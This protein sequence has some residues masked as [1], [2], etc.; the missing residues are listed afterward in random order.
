M[1]E[2][3]KS[4]QYDDAVYCP[5]THTLENVGTYTGDE[6]PTSDYCTGCNE[7]FTLEDLETTE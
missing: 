6:Q 3:T 2:H 7:L 5:V 1:I 4:A